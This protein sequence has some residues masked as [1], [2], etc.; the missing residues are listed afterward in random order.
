MAKVDGGE[1]TE[2]IAEPLK[3]PRRATRA[4]CV[5]LCA[6]VAAVSLAVPCT[7]RAGKEATPA[8]SSSCGAS[9]TI[10]NRGRH[11]ILHVVAD[12]SG[13]NASAGQPPGADTSPHWA[14]DL[15]GDYVL[16]PGENFRPFADSSDTGHKTQWYRMQITYDDGHAFHE[17]V[18]ICKNNL[19]LRY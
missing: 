6:S 16:R 10:Y 13:E 19:E 17:L 3:H 7:A 12:E 14:G 1:E 8:P 18:D 11:T 5:V 4:L 2:R 9:F 15:L